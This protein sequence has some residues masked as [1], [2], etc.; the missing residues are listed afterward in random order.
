MGVNHLLL[1]VLDGNH[2]AQR[3]Y[4]ALGFQ[5]IGEPKFLRAFGRW[6]QRLGVP[7]SCLTQ[8]MPTAGSLSLDHGPSS[9]AQEIHRFQGAPDVIYG[10]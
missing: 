7:I 2:D 3:A 6:E 1:W 10:V 5:P 8:P 4:E 9:Q